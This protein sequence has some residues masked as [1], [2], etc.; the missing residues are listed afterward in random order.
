MITSLY[1]KFKL[2]LKNNLNLN[3]C[4]KLNRSIFY[5]PCNLKI[6][7]LIKYG[8]KAIESVALVVFFLE[9]SLDFSA[10]ACGV[11]SMVLIM[12]KN[13]LITEVCCVNLLF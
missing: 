6:A 8:S 1:Y 2:K 9:E 4:N 3:L 7:N 12:F 10:T 11:S 13:Y 5:K